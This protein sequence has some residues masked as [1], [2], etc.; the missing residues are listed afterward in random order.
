MKKLIITLFILLPLPSSDIL[1]EFSAESDLQDWYVVNDGV[2]GGLSTSTLSFS[3]SGHGLFTGTVRLENN[4]GFCSLRHRFARKEVQGYR[5]LKIR[6]K[7]DG[8]TYQFRV[9]TNS[10]D[11]YSYVYDFQTTSDWMEIQI[12]FE[13]LKPA[14]RGRQLN[15]P[16]FPGASM[17]EVGILIG[18]KKAEDFRLLI[19][20]IR[21]E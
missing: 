3:D 7:G 14:F 17:E 5:A 16:G 8:K 20:W 15:M 19:D 12:P 18:N 10:R 4:G 21:L 13:E 6:V 11:Y 9:K 1:Y 2:M